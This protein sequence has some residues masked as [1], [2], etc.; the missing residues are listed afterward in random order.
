MSPLK[1]DKYLT[2]RTNLSIT[3]LKAKKTEKQ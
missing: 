1:I 3:L 2:H